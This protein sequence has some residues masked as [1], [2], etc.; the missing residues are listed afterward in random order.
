MQPEWFLTHHPQ[1]GWPRS[2]FTCSAV[3]DHESWLLNGFVVCCPRM[4]FAE[5]GS[6]G[7]GAV[8]QHAPGGTHDKRQL[9]IPV[10]LTHHVSLY[11]PCAVCI[12]R[13]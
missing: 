3:S 13:S 4:H 8:V 12:S 5:A 11:S 1:L 6:A 7:R 10:D 9:R 2:H